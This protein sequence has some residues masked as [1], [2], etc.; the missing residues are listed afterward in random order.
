MRAEDVSMG[1]KSVRLTQSQAATKLGVSQP[2]LCLLEAGRRAVPPRLARKVVS[3]YRL[4]ATALPLMDKPSPA[5]PQ[6]LA[7]ELAA[8][9]YPGFSHLK[10]RKKRNPAELLCLALSRNDLDSRVT[11]ALPWVVLNYPDLDWNWL[12]SRSKQN[13]LQNRL[14]FV[15]DIARRVAE[16]RREPGA[17]SL[18][19]YEAE[20]E[21][22][23]LAR[24]DTLC[25]NFL[26]NAEKSWLRQ[27]RPEEAKHWNLLTDLT[28]Q[29]LSYA[30]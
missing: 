3:L 10:R 1:R 23:R 20:L 22:V 6:E 26:T 9:G 7:E 16:A 15:T 28:P 19:S 8:L 13:A 17:A 14:G 2:Y 21:N 27:Q 18:G 25:Q 4:P 29:H 30:A 5:D 24:E 11:E 12:V